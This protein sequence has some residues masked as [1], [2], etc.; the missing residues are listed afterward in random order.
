MRRL[1]PFS[2]LFAVLAAT[3]V[4]AGTGRIVAAHAQADDAPVY[5]KDNPAV[6]QLEVQMIF[7]EVRQERAEARERARHAKSA[8]A[9]TKR[10]AKAEHVMDED[11]AAGRLVTGASTVHMATPASGQNTLVAPTNVQL[12]D[13]SGDL[14]GAGQAEQ[15]SAI[16]GNYGIGAFNNGQGFNTNGDVQGMSYTNNGGAT[17]V[18]TPAVGAAPAGSPAHYPASPLRTWTSD[19]VVSANEKTGDFW[20][21]G[22]N[23]FATGF[24]GVGAVRVT[25][26]GGVFTWDSPRVIANYSNSAASADKQWFAADSSNGNL[27]A[28]WTRFDA[29]DHIM[30][31]RSTDNGVTWS[32]EVQISSLG[33]DGLVQGSRVE[34]GPKGEVYVCWSVLGS[35]DADFFKVRKSTDGGL[36]FSSEVVAT[37]EYSNFG[38]GAPGFNRQR[39]IT[40]PSLGIDRSTGPNRGRQ[41]IAFEDC[42]NWYD[43][44]LGGSG[45]KT[46][47]EPNGFFLSSTP[48]TPGQRLRGNITTTADLDYWTFNGTQGTTY[49]FWCDSLRS[50]LTYSMRIFCT[51]TTG[52][53]TRLAGSGDLSNAGRQGFIVWTAPTT[54][55]YYLRMAPGSTGGYRIE[56]GID[57]PSGPP[58]R[59]RDWRDDFVTYSDDATTWSNP[60]RVNDDPAY[61][62]NWLPEVQVGCD[63]FPYVMWFDFRDA[64][65]KCGGLANI[66]LT[67]ST[68]GGNTWA[69]NQILTT[70]QTNF[71]TAASNI[72]PNEGDYNGMY[73]GKNINLSWADGRLG[74]ADVFEAK[75]VT[76]PSLSCPNDTTVLANSTYL[77][78]WNL[79]NPNV[80]FNDVYNVTITC[81]RNWPGFP[82]NGNFPIAAGGSLGISPMIGVPDTAA[83]GDVHICI[84]ASCGGGCLVQ[85]CVTLHVVNPVTATLATLVDA[86][87]SDGGVRLMWDVFTSSPVNVY[88]SQDNGT[89]WLRLAAVTPD[90]QHHVSYVDAGVTRGATYSYRLGVPSS[91]G[92]VAAGQTSVTVPMSAEFALQGARPNPT[93]GRMTIAFS[94]KDNASA[95]IELVDLGGRRVFSR[96]VGSMGAG[97]HVVPLDNANLPIGIYAVRLTQHGRTL[98]SKV[99]VIR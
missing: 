26:P 72:A 20:Y 60:T 58:E 14:A 34:V 64:V 93:V 17:W 6:K 39:G 1:F 19:P 25:F 27:Y 89:S 3:L 16:V 66:Y 55:V 90:G 24:N 65:P 50:A 81:D 56:T 62:D 42:V 53:G 88:R 69:A 29:S 22:L 80:M 51:D 68:D 41:Y 84:T 4:F 85:C 74:D 83:N 63:G 43:D 86:S 57:T 96:E 32:P 82:I 75:L 21:C 5:A 79:T 44:P 54:A 15:R 49:I 40:F 48:F 70:A 94:L 92:E 61:Y 7:D 18:K 99:T 67:R 38:T 33:D 95:T 37:S 13:K 73:G 2:R 91:G 35:V 12:N 28:T 30:F 8:K 97:F 98:S 76:G 11:V 23:S 87:A 46:E 78:W 71:T 59:A 45:P 47:V 77:P 10:G 31:S 52:G 36:T 9:H